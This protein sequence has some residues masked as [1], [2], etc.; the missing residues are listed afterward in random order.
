[1]DELQALEA[2]ATR[3]FEFLREHGFTGPQITRHPNDATLV[4]QKSPLFIELQ[5]IL[6][7]GHGHLLLGKS[8]PG[9]RV[10]GGYVK[11]GDVVKE[12]FERTARRIGR[13]ALAEQAVAY[14]PSQGAR[15]GISPSNY[16]RRVLA[17]VAHYAD[18]LRAVSHELFADSNA[19]AEQIGKISLDP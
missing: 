4:W 13:P 11:G 15:G 19:T 9:S 14:R 12:H 5:L 17:D 10:E 16:A 8:T 18:S 6:S 7:E 1:M 2:L 3:Q